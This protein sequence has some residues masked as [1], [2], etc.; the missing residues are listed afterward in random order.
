MRHGGIPGKTRSEVL[1]GSAFRAGVSVAVPL[2]KSQKST[3]AQGR[4][5]A[6][7]FP[8]KHEPNPLS[9]PDRGISHHHRTA[10]TRRRSYFPRSAPQ[11]NLAAAMSTGEMAAT[12]MSQGAEITLWLSS[13]MAP[14]VGPSD[15]FEIDRAHVISTTA[16]RDRGKGNR[17]SFVASPLIG[18][19]GN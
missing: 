16:R 2:G 3:S 18:R 15:Q 19:K 9:A 11:N 12:N 4:E 13:V 8:A 17:C 10:K 6:L 1:P 7:S 14:P 5:T